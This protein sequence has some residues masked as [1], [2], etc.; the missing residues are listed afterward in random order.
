MQISVTGRHLDIGEA[1]KTHV[2][3]RLNAIA[4]KY[5]DRAMDAQVTLAKEAHQYRVDCTMHANQ[6]T[7]L[8]ARATGSDIYGT[9]DGAADKIEKQLR[10]Y[11]RRIKNHHALSRRE[12]VETLMAQAYVLAPETEAPD[13]EGDDQGAEADGGDPVIIAETQ[14]EIPRVSVGDAVMIMDLQEATA[15]MFRNIRNDELNMV[16]RRPDG[17]I[18]WVDPAKG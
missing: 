7:V 1:F 3:D 13:Q 17:N 4:H 2:E 5:F 18:G 6:G 11:K 8:Q 9:F 15:L 14:T 12:G 16:Y 10:R